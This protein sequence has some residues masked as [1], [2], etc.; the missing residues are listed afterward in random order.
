MECVGLLGVRIG[1][2]TAYMGCGSTGN[3]FNGVEGG[4]ICWNGGDAVDVRAANGLSIQASDCQKKYQRYG[5]F[6]FHFMVTNSLR[7]PSIR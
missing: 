4:W 1:Y 2:S 6:R 7:H 5:R 3:N